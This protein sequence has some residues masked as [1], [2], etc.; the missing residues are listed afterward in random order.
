MISEFK[1]ICPNIGSSENHIEKRVMIV[2]EG[3]REEKNISSQ[4]QA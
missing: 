2:Q 3:L 4:G 1:D